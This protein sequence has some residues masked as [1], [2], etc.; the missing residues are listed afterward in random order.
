MYS[1]EIVHLRVSCWIFIHIIPNT[2]SFTHTSNSTFFTHTSV[3][4]NQA[5]YS[6]LVQPLLLAAACS[7]LVGHMTIIVTYYF[8]T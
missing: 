6:L 5:I 2:A 1:K 7:L 8:S 3:L 4:R